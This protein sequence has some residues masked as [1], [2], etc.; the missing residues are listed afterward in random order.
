MKNNLNKICTFFLF[1]A[2]VPCMFASGKKDKELK[3]AVK[4]GGDAVPFAY[5][6][7]NKPKLGKDIQFTLSVCNDYE[8]VL[9]QVMD[10]DGQLGLLPLEAAAKTFTLAGGKVVMLGVCENGNVY[11]LSKNAGLSA[12]TQLKG[13]TLAA[14]HEGSVS[15]SVIRYLLK[16]AGLSVGEGQDSVKLDYSIPASGMTAALHSGDALYALMPEPY[17]TVAEIKGQGIVRNIDFQKEYAAVEDGAAFPAYVL[18]AN[19]AYVEL[20]GEYVRA[21]ADA[22][23]KAVSWTNGKAFRAAVLAQKYELGMMAPVVANSIPHASYTW[24]YAAEAR[25]VVEAVLKICLDANPDSIGGRLPD[26]TFYYV[27]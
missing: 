11:L 16:K 9:A 10:E 3:V 1:F 8:E 2:L 13:K 21:F 24:L 19:A 6:C 18:V 5:L 20:N 22:Y 25:N 23:K 12:L 27:F 17:A 15:D 26:E 7:E 14:V 4:K